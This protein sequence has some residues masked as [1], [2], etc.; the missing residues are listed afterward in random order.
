VI[1][2]CRRSGAGEDGQ[3]WLWRSAV[4][5]EFIAGFS[6]NFSLASDVDDTMINS[7]MFNAIAAAPLGLDQRWQ[8]FV[9]G[10]VGALTLRT[11]DDTEAALGIGEVDETDLGG[12]VGFGIMAFGDQWGF[13]GEGR[14]FTQLGDPDTDSVFLN[15]LN[16][17]R[18]NAGV[19]Y[20]W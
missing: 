13:R 8:P 3:R 20:R 14:Y 10:G 5:A 9:S 7:Y 4:G 15:D 17:W 1:A 19:A 6:P 11:G 18:A 12:N 2:L 16:F